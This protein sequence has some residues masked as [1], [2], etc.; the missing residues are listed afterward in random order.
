MRKGS[1]MLLQLV[2]RAAG[3]DEMDLVEIETAVRGAGH[4]QVAM[5]NRVEGSAKEGDAARM[6][7]YGGALR[8]RGGQYPSQGRCSIFSQIGKGGERVN[9]L[10]GIKRFLQAEVSRRNI[11][12]KGFRR[13]SPMGKTSPSG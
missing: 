11:W 10:C 1:Q 13:A 2:R 3:G 4:G 8:L 12:C 5:V 6:K 9:T 7:F